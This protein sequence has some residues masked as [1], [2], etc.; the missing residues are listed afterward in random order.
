MTTEFCGRVDCERRIP[1]PTRNVADLVE[2]A[3][4]RQDDLREAESGHVREIMVLRDNFSEKL[5]EA[6]TGR[7]DAIRAVDV[8]AVQRAAE[9]AAEA[10]QTLAAQVP[11]TAEAVRTALAAT[12]A[13]I[14][15]DIQ[16]LR[17]AQY[18]QQGQK[19][20]VVDSG[21]NDMARRA[22]LTAR[23]AVLVA[24]A[25]PL[26]VLIVGAATHGKF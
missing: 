7:I 16:A 22:A 4:T 25:S 18:E 2:A 21:A 26:I 15:S 3:I 13:P 9:V 17:Q 11:I 20:A 12:V 5:R 10:V 1:D 23:N 8:A 6:E 14:L 19:A 24:A